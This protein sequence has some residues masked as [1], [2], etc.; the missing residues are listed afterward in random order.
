MSKLLEQFNKS[1]GLLGAIDAITDRRAFITLFATFAVV[2][3]LTAVVGAAAASLMFN[4]HFDL[5][6][7]VGAIGTLASLILLLIG[8]SATGFLL[9]DRVHGREQKTVGQA[10]LFS[11][12]TLH[13]MLGALLILLVIG[14]LAV[15]LAFV[16]ILLCK[17]P[18]VG[19]LLYAI[20]APAC[21]L[22]LGTIVFGGY[23]IVA[24]HGPAIWEGH[25]VLRTVGVLGTIFRRR[26]FPVVVQMILLAL[27]VA[28]VGM[29]V[30]AC[31]MAGITLT[32]A[33]SVPLLGQ[34]FSA[35][36][37]EALL[38][39]MIGGHGNGSGYLAAA[40]FGLAL[41]TGLAITLPLLVALA[42]N[43][44]IF[45]NVTEDLST[46][47]IERQLQDA[48]DAARAK[49]EQARRQLNEARSQLA[50]APVAAP[51]TPHCSHC[52]ATAAADDVFCG[53][54]GKRII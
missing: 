47:E 44:I 19:P 22:F 39:G 36:S 51:V 12:A 23:F 48:V 53:N 31:I 54:C 4:G 28:L 17:I 29:L 40:M 11:L 15:A 6:K 24:L 30:A 41:L 49:G 9:N 14:V 50:S 52:S 20:V 37:P 2:A 1:Q 13:R 21:A 18:G 26:L 32:G 33:M 38:G 35:M 27:L 43:C 46:A 10:L 8:V 45:A 16:A 3:M 42:G 5:G 25:P 7:G 34:G